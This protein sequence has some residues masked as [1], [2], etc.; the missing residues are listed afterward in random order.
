MYFVELNGERISVA[1][2]S[3]MPSPPIDAGSVERFAQQY[4]TGS[5]DVVRSVLIEANPSI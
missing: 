2:T 3:G 1:A 4:Y 5:S